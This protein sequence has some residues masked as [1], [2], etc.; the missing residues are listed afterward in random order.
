MVSVIPDRRWNVLRPLGFI[1]T[2]RA[3]SVVSPLLS[4]SMRAASSMRRS[5][6][7]IDERCVDGADV[8][9]TIDV[10]LIDRDRPRLSV[11]AR[12]IDGETTR[13]PHETFASSIDAGCIDRESAAGEIDAG[14]IE[15]E[16]ESSHHR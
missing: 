2:M 7:T 9:S 14:C 1:I 13:S 12:C 5:R 15:H 10:A 6:L 11:D 3:A 4:K 16:T 8:A